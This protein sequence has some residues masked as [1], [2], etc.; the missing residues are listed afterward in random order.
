M[1]R[2]GIKVVSDEA[3]RLL[4]IT[5]RAQFERHIDRFIAERSGAPS[6]RRRI[7]AAG[8]V[9]LRWLLMLIRSQLR[10]I[11]GLVIIYKLHVMALSRA[12]KEIKIEFW[13]EELKQRS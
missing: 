11:Y 7:P 8:G 5:D 10:G 12:G 3:V 1:E 2:D 13:W 4:E 9:L 6:S